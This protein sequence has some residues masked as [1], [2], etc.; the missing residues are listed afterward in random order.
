L[1]LTRDSWGASARLSGYRSALEAHGR[2]VDDALV[3]WRPGTVHAGRES[4]LEVLALSP[5]PSALVVA[6]NLQTVG[7]VGTVAEL[8]L[9]IPRD[10]SVVGFGHPG[11][12]F[13]PAVPL[14][15]ISHDVDAVGRQAARLLLERLRT[16]QREPVH[17]LVLACDLEVRGS[18]GPPPP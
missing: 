12:D 8:G 11:F 4:L 10:L 15:V 18:T 1:N 6:A 13:W 5:A 3:R 7:V 16:R 14:T 9:R 2:A 17:R